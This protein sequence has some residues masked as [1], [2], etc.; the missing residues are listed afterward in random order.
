MPDL[1]ENL[2]ANIVGQLRDKKFV[3]WHRTAKGKCSGAIEITQA[4]IDEIED[5][6]RV[7]VP[8]DELLRPR[9]SAATILSFIFGA[10]FLAALLAIGIFVREPTPFLV[11]IAKIIAAL[12]AAGV[13]AI[14][15]GF[16]NLKLSWGTDL[17]VRAGGAIALFVLVYFFVPAGLVGG[18]HPSRTPPAIAGGGR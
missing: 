5:L 11:T 4:G 12:A 9:M 6:D 2:L 7:V 14:I 8:P 16:L 15:P 13:G 3:K 17:V 1:S 10:V 18:D